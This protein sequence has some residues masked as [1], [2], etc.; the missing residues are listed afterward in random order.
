MTAGGGVRLKAEMTLLNGCTVIIGTDKQCELG[1]FLL[2][3]LSE[4]NHHISFFGAKL[5]PE[6]VSLPLSH[7]FNH[8]S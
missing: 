2:D 7:G 1:S 6:L 3:N 5:L 8:L 4:P